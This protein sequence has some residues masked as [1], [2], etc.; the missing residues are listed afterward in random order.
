MKFQCLRGRCVKRHRHVPRRSL[1]ARV[2]NDVFK[3]RH[4][5]GFHKIHRG[6]VVKPRVGEKFINEGV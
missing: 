5:I 4:N 1:K 2:F 6:V 3:Q